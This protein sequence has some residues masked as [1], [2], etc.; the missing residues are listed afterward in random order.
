MKKVLLGLMAVLAVAIGA[1]ALYVA[2]RQHLRFDVAPPAIAAT[3][4]STAIARGR[5]LVRH[6]AS[7][8]GCHGD[9]TMREQA[10]AGEEIPLTG[11]FE[12]SIP[13]GKFYPRNITPDSATGIGAFTDGQIARALR[14]GVG[15]DGRALL[16]FMEMQGLSDED[17]VAVISY[18]RSQPPV[19]HVV[20]DHQY[21]FLGTIVKA[22]VLSKPVGPKETPPVRNPSGATIENGRYLV[23]AVAN[24]WACHTERDYNTGQMVGAHLAGGKMPDDFN[25]KRIWFPPNLTSDPATGRLAQFTE[26]EFVARFHAGRLIP[27]SPMP[28]SEFRGLHE[29]DVR[30]IYRYLK[31]VPP[32]VHATGPA[33]V[34]KP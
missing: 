31:S 2:S 21:N 33:F 13:P 5:Y 20:P 26:D 32:V 10:E 15:N 12:F 19:H 1:F 8:G 4:D 16:P 28:W 6:L 24:C 22:T 34:D 3:T 7:C 18:L 30:A 25:P 14:D 29:E 27:G 11:G 23:E 17:L 9:P